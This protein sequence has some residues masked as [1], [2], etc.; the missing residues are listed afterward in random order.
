M[1]P[2][3]GDGAGRLELDDAVPIQTEFQQDL[4]S[5]LRKTWSG[6]CLG[7]AD[8][9]LDRIRDQLEFTRRDDVLVRPDLGVLRGL[10][11][12]LHRGQRSGPCREGFAPLR[13]GP[14]GS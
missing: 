6:T 5:L 9:E 4:V 11:G 7:C 12:V 8:I 10:Q 2:N 1:S 3:L 13:K 14:L